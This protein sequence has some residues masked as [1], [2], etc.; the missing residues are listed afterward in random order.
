MILMSDLSGKSGRL[1]KSPHIWPLTY[2]LRDV[3]GTL[4]STG[5]HVASAV[6]P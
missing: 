5:F 2:G 6:Q 1:W 3:H 4:V